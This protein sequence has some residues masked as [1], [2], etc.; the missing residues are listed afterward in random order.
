MFPL[1][2]TYAPQSSNIR[3]EPHAGLQ[4]IKIDIDIRIIH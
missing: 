2:F 4:M 3:I 1:T